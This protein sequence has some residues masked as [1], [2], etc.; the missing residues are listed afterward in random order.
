MVATGLAVVRLCSCCRLAVCVPVA[1]CPS[2]LA[3][4]LA[5]FG[6]LRFGRL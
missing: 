3:T 5:G 6:R 4:G 1:R 2:E